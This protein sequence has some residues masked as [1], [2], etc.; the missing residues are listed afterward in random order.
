MPILLL[1]YLRKDLNAILLLVTEYFYTVVLLFF[2]SEWPNVLMY[3]CDFS[4][5]VGI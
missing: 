5:P 1:F 4:M 2:Y 3:S